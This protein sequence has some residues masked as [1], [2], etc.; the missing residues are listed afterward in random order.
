MEAWQVAGFDALEKVGYLNVLRCLVMSHA[1][2]VWWY[3]DSRVVGTSILHGGTVSFVNTG[4]R[5]IAISAHH[6]YEQYL[7]DKAADSGVKCQFGGVTV[8]PEKYVIDS[9]RKL[10]LVTFDLPVVLATATGAT[11]HNSPSWPPAKLAESDIVILG[12]YPGNRR[13]EGAQAL[14][15]DFV[16]FIGRIAQSSDDHAS[17]YLNIPNSHWP[18]G[19]RLCESPNL[20]GMS[21]G[22]VFRLITDPIE[23]LEFSGV[24]YE[25]HQTY[26]LVF[27]SHAS[28]IRSDGTLEK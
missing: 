4:R 10:D 11:I 13:L 3:D 6:V 18:Q 21:G 26:E 8:E 16:S 27:C 25:S 23:S 5:V 19:E 24:I 15:S 28:F 20:G 7:R 12:G 9:D 22:P 1:T 2:P 14:D 17:M